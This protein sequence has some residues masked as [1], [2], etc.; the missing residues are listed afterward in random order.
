MLKNCVFE[1]TV[2]AALDHLA[3]GTILL[4]AVSGGADSTAMLTALASLRCNKDFAQKSF[5]INVLHVE[6]GMRPAEESRG[7]ALAVKKLC[8]TLDIP[9][10]ITSIQP[11]RIQKAAGEWG[12]GPEASARF[13]RMRAL[14]REARRINAVKILTAH[15]HDDL[16][17]NILIRILRGAGPRG[18]ALMPRERGKFLRPLL[19]L[20]R[21]DVLAYLEKKGFVFRT[22]SSNKETRYLRNRIRHKLIPCL[23]EFFPYW[24]SSLYSLAETQTLAADFITK[25]AKKQLPW[26]QDLDDNAGLWVKVQDFMLQTPIIQEEAVFLAHNLLAAG[27]SSRVLRRRSLRRLLQDFKTGKTQT[28][29]LGPISLKKD[30]EKVHVTGKVTSKDSGGFEYGFGIVIDSPGSYNY[31]G[32]SIKTESETENIINNQTDNQAEEVFYA[33][34]PFVLKKW[35]KK[36]IIV[37]TGQKRC[38]S[39][40]L[41]REERTAY[42]GFITAL[43]KEGNAAFIGLGRGKPALLY[44]RDS[45]PELPIFRVTVKNFFNGSTD[46]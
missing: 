20:S 45:N 29:D 31:K 28:G 10:R 27:D 17:E 5:S 18:L 19:D 30:A 6:H 4:A 23:D 39:D 24:R 15:T 22:D 11:G 42:K 35:V 16:L 34:L 41:N 40:I 46:V 3:G 2:L 21:K 36:D 43:D 1:A 8:K 44:R 7:D 26:K 37:K 38:L 25:E 13:F 9:C 33:Q 14:K 12:L 32:I